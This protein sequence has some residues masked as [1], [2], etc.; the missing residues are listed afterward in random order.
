MANREVDVVIPCYNMSKYLP[1]AIES[2]LA[3]TYKPLR[4]V[5]VDDGSTEDIRSLVE[6]YHGAVDYVR[7]FNAGLPAARNT[8]I[9]CT[10]GAYL[11]F[12]DADD[13]IL[14]SKIASQVQFLDDHPEVD[15][16]HGRS[17]LFSDDNVLFP[18]AD[19]RPFRQWDDYLIPLSIMC[20][21]PVHSAL[22]RRRLIDRVGLFPEEMRTG[23]EDWAFWLSCILNR[24]VFAH[25]PTV[26]AL[27]RK[28]EQSMSTNVGRLA[29]NEYN[30]IRLA[31]I[32]FEQAGLVK[33]RRGKIISCGIRFVAARLFSLSDKSRYSE[34][35]SL[36]IKIESIANGKIPASKTYT[37]APILYL[38]ISNDLFELGQ[39]ELACFCFLHAGDIRILREETIEK[40]LS[41]V[42]DGVV[43]MIEEFV[44]KISID[45]NPIQI[46]V[47]PDPPPFG[48]E[49]TFFENL[50]K[51]IPQNAFYS[52]YLIHQLGLLDQ[53]MERLQEAINKFERAVA[54][55]PCYYLFYEDLIRALRK[56]DRGAEAEK[57]VR[58]LL[59]IA[60]NS[61]YGHYY[62]G[63]EFFRR[64]HLIAGIRSIIWS[65]FAD[66]SSCLRYMVRDFDNFV[67]KYLGPRAMRYRIRIANAIASQ[68]WFR[69]LVK[70]LT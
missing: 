63:K 28:H 59:Y 6:S 30:W 27:Y 69:R 38:H 61:S 1:Q 44:P 24:A 56:G 62:M 39:P 49:S 29:A 43:K 2:S 65:L 31:A 58:H 3:Q 48:L 55:N 23:C 64:F 50:E 25:S 36:A 12:L 5:V 60:G 16:V 47:S 21:F 11:C 57:V 53:K 7:Q 13:I 68:A 54:L 14:P 67:F 15:L 8:G 32:K 34:L 19:W 40:G 18:Y 4:V 17:L 41:G 20:P 26:N 22:V 51:N 10:D 42:F 9:K 45:V 35:M 66:P 33:G 70:A 37:S 52:S 46:P